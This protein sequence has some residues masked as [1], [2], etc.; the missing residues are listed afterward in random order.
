MR[1]IRP[2]PHLFWYLKDDIELDLSEPSVLDMYVQQTV[3]HGNTEDIK[4]LFKEVGYN[5]FKE[6]F[7]RLRFFLPCEVRKFWEDFFG[8]TESDT[9][10]STK[11]IW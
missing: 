4:T 7:L 5:Q 10:R 11:G 8:I 3:T 2:K 1:K 6:A 9:R